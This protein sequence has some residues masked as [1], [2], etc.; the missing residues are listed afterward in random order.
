VAIAV[1]TQTIAIENV[2]AANRVE[3]IG[4]FYA[5]ARLFPRG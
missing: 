2:R 4:A 1:A 5:R 3:I